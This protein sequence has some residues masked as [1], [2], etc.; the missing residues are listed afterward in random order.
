MAM[1][2]A[3]E[4]LMAA[5]AIRGFAEALVLVEVSVEVGAGAAVAAEADLV[6]GS[7]FKLAVSYRK[8]GY[9]AKR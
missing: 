5:G 2:P 3:M 1:V 9:H 6:I 8:D 7:R 4:C